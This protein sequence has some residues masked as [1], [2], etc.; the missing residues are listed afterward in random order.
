MSML[1]AAVNDPS[2]ATPSR[3]TVENPDS[4]NVTVYVPARKSTMRYWPL[5]SVVAVLTFSIS[6][7][8]AASTVTP[9]QPP[10]AR[11]RRD[12]LRRMCA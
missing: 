6:A 5:P 11:Q 10:G 4:E 7:G 8:L 3:L 9:E 1:M 12:L 2:S